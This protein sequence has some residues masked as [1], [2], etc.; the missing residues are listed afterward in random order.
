MSRPFSNTLFPSKLDSNNKTVFP[1]KLDTSISLQNSYINLVTSDVFTNIQNLLIQ[2]SLGNF[3]YVIANLTRENFNQYAIELF[4]LQQ[5]SNDA[6]YQ[7]TLIFLNNSL[8]ELHQAVFQSNLLIS[9]NLQIIADN[10]KLSI[11]Q[12]IAE[13]TLYLNNLKNSANQIFP[14]SIINI[15]AVAL[16][17]EYQQYI[18]LYGFPSGG[19]FEVNK[20]AAII[21]S[22]A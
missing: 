13:L 3:E 12:N 2:Y 9:A 6:N 16:K 10:S 1:S 19:V 7:K 11:L 15:P 20:L 18:T 4:S 22:L 14:E 8:N 21:L 5:Y 17:P